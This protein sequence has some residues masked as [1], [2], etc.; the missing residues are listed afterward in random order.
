VKRS[1]LWYNSRSVLLPFKDTTNIKKVVL[2]INKRGKLSEESEV[3]GLMIGLLLYVIQVSRELE[4]VKAI[5]IE[6]LHP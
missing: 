4:L 3:I 1:V 5:Q 2:T 6:P